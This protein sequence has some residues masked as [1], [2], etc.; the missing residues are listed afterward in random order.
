[1]NWCKHRISFNASLA[2]NVFYTDESMN[3]SSCTTGQ[4]EDRW[5]RRLGYWWLSGNR[6]SLRGEITIIGSQG[7]LDI[8]NT[9]VCMLTMVCV[10]VYMYAVGK[11]MTIYC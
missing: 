8:K 6:K 9:H 3:V 2:A 11:V 1:M 5:N 4:D 7:K 10:V